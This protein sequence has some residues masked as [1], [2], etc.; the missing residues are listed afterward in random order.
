M[1]TIAQFLGFKSYCPFCYKRCSNIHWYDVWMSYF[2]DFPLND[3]VSPENVTESLQLKIHIYNT[4]CERPYSVFLS[5]LPFQMSVCFSS[6]QTEESRHPVGSSEWKSRCREKFWVRH[7]GQD[8]S[9]LNRCVRCVTCCCVCW[10]V[11]CSCVLMS[12]WEWRSSADEP[13]SP[14]QR[15]SV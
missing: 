5:Y 14:C 1:A 7:V 2:I 8:K 6:S 4:V 15:S 10:C 11:V 9:Q 3:V 12:S 13:T